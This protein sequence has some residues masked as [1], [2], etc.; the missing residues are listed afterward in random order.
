MALFDGP[1]A[2]VRAWV[3]P[4]GIKVR[5]IA[6]CS[7]ASVQ[8]VGCRALSGSRKRILSR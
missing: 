5:V 4:S 8:E 7:H 1:E 6:I 3:D 2:V